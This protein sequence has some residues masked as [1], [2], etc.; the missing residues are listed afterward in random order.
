MP[1]PRRRPTEDLRPAGVR[2]RTALSALSSR[3]PL[4]LYR[5]Y[6]CSLRRDARLTR[7]AG[8][9]PRDQRDHHLAAVRAPTRRTTVSAAGI[10]FIN[11]A[12]GVVP[13]STISVLA[14]SG[15]CTVICG[16]CGNGVRRACAAGPHCTYSS[17]SSQHL[18]RSSRARN[19]AR[20]MI[21]CRVHRSRGREPQLGRPLS[22]ADK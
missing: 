13:Y 9:R 5:T 14:S 15:P 2:R 6:S 22:N 1:R 17:H 4:Q 8:P 7:G 3:H 19:R 12:R 20:P 16:M 18:V 10:I 11:H 21:A